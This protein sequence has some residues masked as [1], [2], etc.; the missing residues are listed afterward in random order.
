[1]NECYFRLQ[2]VKRLRS[3]IIEELKGRGFPA[4]MEKDELVVGRGK[5]RLMFPDDVV[6]DAV[7]MIVRSAECFRSEHEDLRAF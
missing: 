1:M 5:K 3:A 6:Y 4:K 7:S 2:L